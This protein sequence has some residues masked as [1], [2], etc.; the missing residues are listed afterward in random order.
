MRRR[1]FVASAVLA[2]ALAGD[3]DGLRRD[4]HEEV[5]WCGFETCQDA[6]QLNELPAY[7]ERP[8]LSL[9]ACG[10]AV[11]KERQRCVDGTFVYSED[12][13]QCCTIASEYVLDV[14]RKA[15]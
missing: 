7:Q 3:N 5:L 9:D 14:R 11:A 6:L 15:P 10:A 2:V 13:C 1:L 8:L 12:G 4:T